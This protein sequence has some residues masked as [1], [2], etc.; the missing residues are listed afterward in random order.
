MISPTMRP[1]ISPPRLNRSLREITPTTDPV[2]GSTTGPP[3]RTHAR[4]QTLAQTH[5][6]TNQSL[7]IVFL[8]SRLQKW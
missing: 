8:P 7:L 4:G 1:P 3:S 2:S 6:R 5:S